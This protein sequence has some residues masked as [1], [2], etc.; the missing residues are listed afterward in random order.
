MGYQDTQDYFERLNGFTEV[1][2]VSDDDDDDDGLFRN[3][4]DHDSEFNICPGDN[5]NSP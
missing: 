2:S 3:L 4:V 5:T 1:I